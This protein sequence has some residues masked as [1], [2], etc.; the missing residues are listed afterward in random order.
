M[1]WRTIKRALEVAGSLVAAAL[2]A[3]GCA[4]P[5][6]EPVVLETEEV[7]APIDAE[8][9]TEDDLKARPRRESL[10]G[11]IPGDF[12]PD[13]AVVMPASVVDFGSAGDGRAYLELDTERTPAQALSWLGRALPAA[14]WTVR[15]VGGER[16]EASKGPREVVYLLRDLAPGSRVRIEYPAQ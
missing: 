16:I 10:S 14:G 13:L 7:A 4:S 8:A 6:P 11:V 1:K 15:V 2:L 9:S 12:P 3:A 5:E